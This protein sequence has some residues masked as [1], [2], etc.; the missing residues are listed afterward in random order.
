MLCMCG[1]MLCPRN[2]TEGSSPVRKVQQRW[3]ME[4]VSSRGT[5]MAVSSCGV[6]GRHCASAAT[7]SAQS[8]AQQTEARASAVSSKGACAACW[9]PGSIER[10]SGMLGKVGM[11]G[12]SSLKSPRPKGSACRG[13]LRGLAGP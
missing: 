11:V 9:R 13:R 4:M 5:R 6:M 2:G 3:R 1:D 10:M 12:M 8:A 7:R